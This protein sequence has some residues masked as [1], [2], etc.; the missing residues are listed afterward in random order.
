MHTSTEYVMLQ[1]R[2]RE[3][4][5]RSP[6]WQHQVEAARLRRGRPWRQRVTATARR[7]ATVVRR[8]VRPV[9]GAVVTQGEGS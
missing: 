8:P 4:K 3:M 2:L 7:F 1:E 5:Y 9:R 6:E